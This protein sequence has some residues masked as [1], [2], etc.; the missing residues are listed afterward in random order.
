MSYTRTDQ[1]CPRDGHRFPES[2]MLGMKSRFHNKASHHFQAAKFQ[3]KFV[4][5]A[6]L[7]VASYV[8][9]KNRIEHGCSQT[10]P[11]QH[12]ADSPT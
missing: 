6:A 3:P 7:E 1:K 5:D 10:I 9:S 2:V 8:C 11:N 4:N 12:D